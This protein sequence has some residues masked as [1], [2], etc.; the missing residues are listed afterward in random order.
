MLCV[1]SKYILMAFVSDSVSSDVAEELPRNLS[2]F[3][4]M[5]YWKDSTKIPIILCIYLVTHL[6]IFRRMLYCIGI[7]NL[8]AN[9][10][11]YI[12]ILSRPTNYIQKKVELYQ[13]DSIKMLIVLY[14]L[15]YTPI[16][17]NQYIIYMLT[18]GI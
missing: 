5:L 15:P 2:I 8:D 7:L 16:L 6:I 11:I 13:N 4:R 3:R 9:Y 10:I 14:I 18:V 1:C 12:Y 17:Q